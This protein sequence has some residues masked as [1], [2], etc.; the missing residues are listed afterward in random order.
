M[1]RLQM[2]NQIAVP[3]DGR[4]SSCDSDDA[5]TIP[6][7]QLLR[8]TTLCERIGVALVDRFLCERV[9][10]VCRCWSR[11]RDSV[12]SPSCANWRAMDLTDPL[13]HG[14]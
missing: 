10:C 3:G 7:S 2:D 11:C 9:V 6:G 14:E 8:S 1:G 5:R 4:R 13:R 12:E